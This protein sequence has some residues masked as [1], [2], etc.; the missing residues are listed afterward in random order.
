MPTNPEDM[1]K[2]QE[3]MQNDGGF[4]KLLE[5]PEMLDMSIQMME[6]PMGQQQLEGMAKQTGMSTQT[7]IR[8]MK[9]LVGCAKMYK[10]AKPVLPIIKYGLI[11]LVG[12]YVLKWLGLI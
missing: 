10:K 4:A 2:M 12:S 6:S 11:I 3:Q 8:V 5:N 9:F 1:K 7:L